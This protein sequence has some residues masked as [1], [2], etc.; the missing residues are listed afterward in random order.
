M[1]G[2]AVKAY[3]EATAAR[4]TADGCDVH[5][6]DWHGTAVL[7][8]HRSDFRV[9]WMAT[10]LH[11]LTIV[12]PASDVTRTAWSHSRTRHSS[13]RRRVRDRCAASSP[14]L[15]SSPASSAR[16]SI[17]PRWPGRRR[18]SWRA[19]PAWHARS[20]WTSLP[21]PL[22]ASGVPQPLALSIRDISAASSTCTSPLPSVKAPL[23]ARNTRRGSVQAR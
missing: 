18:S 4:L 8:G 19:S 7:V 1:V 13:M 20:S 17:R 11:L 21:A 16:T 5:T 6:E 22:V 14:V 23:T 9:Q 12:A 3:I 15:P 2:D 10:K